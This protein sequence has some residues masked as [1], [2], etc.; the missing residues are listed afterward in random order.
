MKPASPCALA[1]RGSGKMV[2]SMVVAPTAPRLRED[3]W[4]R[5]AWHLWNCLTTDPDVGKTGSTGYCPE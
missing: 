5:L 3:R 4:N 1:E 2:H